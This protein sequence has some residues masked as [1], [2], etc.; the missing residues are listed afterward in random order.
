MGCLGSG[1]PGLAILEVHAY[2]NI[3]RYT[4][5]CCLVVRYQTHT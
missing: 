3:M 4:V 1:L 5:L 2:A